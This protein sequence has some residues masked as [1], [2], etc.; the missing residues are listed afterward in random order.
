MKAELQIRINLNNF[1]IISDKMDHPKISD[2][3]QC[4]IG[5]PG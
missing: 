1:L 4:G 3:G 5:K 2:V